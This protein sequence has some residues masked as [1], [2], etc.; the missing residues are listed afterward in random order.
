MILLT[1]TAFFSK[2][3]LINA[4]TILMMSAKLAIPNLKTTIF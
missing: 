3:V 4:I 1:I 2:V